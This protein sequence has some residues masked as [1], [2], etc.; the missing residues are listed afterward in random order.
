MD[1]LWL[2]T[3][4]QCTMKTPVTI[5]ECIYITDYIQVHS[6]LSQINIFKAF[7]S[8]ETAVT[9]TYLSKA[10]SSQHRIIF[11]YKIIRTRQ[12]QLIS[13]IGSVCDKKQSVSVINYCYTIFT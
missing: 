1:L 12:T 6:N 10:C 3:E 7:F 4:V 2:Y 5:V 13:I 9:K 11:K 8:G